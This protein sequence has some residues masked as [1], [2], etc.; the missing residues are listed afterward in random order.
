MRRSNRIFLLICA[1]SLFVTEIHSG[2]LFAAATD[3]I[4]STPAAQAGTIESQQP[5]APQS[6]SNA[7]AYQT[8]QNA[9]QSEPPGLQEYLGESEEISLFGMDLRI[10]QRKAEK[11][12]QGLL[13]VD[14]APGS[15]GAY[16]GLHPY[17]QPTRDILNGVGMLAAMA[18][19]PA[20][21][22]VPIVESVP[23]GEAYDLI[24]GVDG[25]RV[26]NFM[27]FY[28]CMREV[29]PGELIYLNLLRNGHRVQV[30]IRITS[31]LPPPQAWVR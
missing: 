23:L 19:P 27:D 13:V 12:I 20:A 28:Y 17:R 15:P 18:F 5:L 31:S 11:Q 1:V 29:Q 22:I 24:I 30:P 21:A 25:A 9:N 2:H 7:A 6:G 26:T 3:E 14:I 8:D 16:A 10:E 4:T